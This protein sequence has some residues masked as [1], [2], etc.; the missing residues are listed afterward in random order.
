MNIM[1]I[2]KNRKWTWAGHISRRMDNRRSA[3]LTVWTR[4]GDKRIEEG[5]EK[6][7]I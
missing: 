2:I 1:S 7:E 3:A 5:N 6:V 4:I